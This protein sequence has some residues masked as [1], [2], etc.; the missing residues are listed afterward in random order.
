MDGADTSSFV[1]VFIVPIVELIGVTVIICAETV[2]TL[3]VKAVISNV[4]SIDV[5]LIIICFVCVIRF[6]CLF[7]LIMDLCL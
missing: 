4:V 3:R 7:F 5:F 1:D 2:E 6:F